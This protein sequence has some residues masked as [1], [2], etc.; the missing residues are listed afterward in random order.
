M[1]PPT[2]TRSVAATERWC[3][4]AAHADL[5]W[6]ESPSNPMLDVA[7]LRTIAAASRPDGAL[8]AVDNSLAGPLAQQPLVVGADVSRTVRDQAPRRSLRSTTGAVLTGQL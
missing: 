6:I 1:R 3:Q 2:G 5:V 4:A 8:L 7:D